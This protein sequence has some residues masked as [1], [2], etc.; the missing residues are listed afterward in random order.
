MS[1]DFLREL[2]W[3]GLLHQVTDLEGLRT[4]LATGRRA[5]YVGFDPTADSLTIGNLVPLMLLVHLQ[6]AGHRPVVVVGGGTGLIGDPSGKEAER[7]LLS[8]EA[9]RKNIAGQ[10]R[11]FERLLDF[12][13]PAAARVLD[14][15]EWLSKLGY[16]EV[17][18]D[19]GKHF[20]VNMMIQ[21]DA[22]HRRLQT[23]EQ[24]ISYT[25]FSYILLQ[26]YDFLHLYRHEGVTLQ[27][28]GSDQWGNIASGCDLIRRHGGEAF[29]LTAPLVTRSDGGKF[30]KSEA[31]AIWLTADR[32]SPYALYQFLLNTDDADVVRL[33]RMFTFLPE[34]EIA[35]IAEAQ[36]QD[37]GAR[38]AQRT[39]AQEV[40]RLLHGAEEL[41]AAEAATQALFGGDLSCLSE[42]L[43]REVLVGAPTSEHDRSLLAT[44]SGLPIVDALALTT[45]VRSRREARD[46]LLQ[47]AITVNG[48]RA[49]LTTVLTPKDLLPGGIIAF[50]RGKKT[51][52]VTRWRP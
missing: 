19:I 3:R 7:Q 48:R 6:R 45:L 17:L 13:G 29:G 23:R 26:A 14:N 16:I 10:R 38:L 32:T 35:A 43:L 22:V 49:E 28:G 2:H 20:S 1:D 8:E 47:G 9:V 40:T 31:G 24:G 30:G 50:R 39:L 51:W 12:S 44:P 41:R 42:D 46:L 36:A 25:E 34:K 4:H 37:P 11:I 21:R 52:H 5:G 27:M 18:R 33:L 15:H